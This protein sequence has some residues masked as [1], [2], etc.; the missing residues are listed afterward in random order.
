LATTYA[1]IDEVALV[2]LSARILELACIIHNHF[3]P[4]RRMT[5]KVRIGAKWK[6]TFEKEAKMS[7]QRVLENTE[8]SD[9]VKL[10]LRE[11]HETL[12][13]LSL[14]RELDMLKEE[15][16]KKLVKRNTRKV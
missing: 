13:P 10:R 1:R 8:V 6:R 16:F 15:L 11:M 9:E 3:R 4:V 5:N 7:Y 2:P 14:K 12:D